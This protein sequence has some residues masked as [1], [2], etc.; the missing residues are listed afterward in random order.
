MLELYSDYLLSQHYLATATGLSRL[1]E[2]PISHDQVTR[3]LNNEQF[4]SKEL[5]KYIKPKLPSCKK[6]RKNVLILDDTLVEKPY[7]KENKAICW[8]YDH[9]KNR[10]IKGINLLTC[11]LDNS[12]VKVPISYHIIK[13]TIYYYDK[14]TKKEKR[15]SPQTKNELFRTMVSQ[16]EKNG[17]D[18]QYVLADSWFGSKE[19]M[20]YLH[21]ELD[22]K[23]VLGLKSNRLVC[24]KHQEGAQTQGYLQ[25][26]E[27]DLKAGLYPVRLKGVAYPLSLLKKVFKNGNGSIG[28]LYLISNDLTL[29]SQE[30]YSLYQRRWGIETYHKSL[31]QHASLSKSPCWSE[32][33]QENHIFLSLVGYCKLELLK[34]K[35]KLNH[36]QLRHYLLLEA[37]RA[38]LEELKRIQ[39]GEFR[40]IQNSAA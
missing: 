21:N 32:L 4:G 30:L 36:Y 20:N 6:K 39:N 8:H 13:K 12:T 14:K 37:N 29:S 28:T 33:S 2:G 16:A 26:K 40:K 18:Y 15:K 27:A 23:F 9:T 3:F 24:I 38:S 11:M 5:W 35:T 10:H 34:V 25:L 22:K 19:T 1:M 31:K 17:L 7:R